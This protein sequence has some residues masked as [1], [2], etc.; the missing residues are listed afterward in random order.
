MLVLLN[1]F[2]KPNSVQMADHIYYLAAK[3]QGGVNV[4]TWK[5][6]TGTGQPL[7]TKTCH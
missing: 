3:K 6:A 4:S 2:E 1:E 5:Y 7:A